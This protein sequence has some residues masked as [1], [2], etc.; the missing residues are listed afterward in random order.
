M[1]KLSKIT[2]IDNF[3]DQHIITVIFWFFFKY[4]EHLFIAFVYIIFT[5]NNSSVIYLQRHMIDEMIRGLYS[6][7]V[8]TLDQF[9]TKEITNHLFE[10][11]RIPHSGIDLPAL[12][13]QR[14]NNFK[15]S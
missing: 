15:F 2:F 14:G 5:D 8:E 4:S 6:T 1:E 10:D 7:P 3:S 12:N 11:K 13:V 9:I